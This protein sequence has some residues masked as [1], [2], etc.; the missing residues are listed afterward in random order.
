MRTLIRS[1]RVVLPLAALALTGSG[2]AAYGAVRDDGV[3]YRTARAGTGSVEQELSLAGVISP[4]GSSDLAFGVDGTVRKV[5]VRQGDE[6]E[7]GDVIAVLDRAG[8]RAAVDRAASDL[9]SAKAQLVDDRTAQTSAVATSST[10]PSS[11]NSSDEAASTSRDG[12]RPRSDN[13]DSS[14]SSASAGKQ[15]PDSTALIK[16]LEKQQEPV[17]TAQ[18]AASTALASAETALAEQQ[19]AC[20]DPVTTTKSTQAATDD[21][22]DGSTDDGGESTPT[23]VLSEACTSAL[24][25]VQTAQRT[26]STAQ[27]TLQ[28]ALETL[29]GTLADAA[30]SVTSDEAAPSSAPAPSAADTSGS[31]EPAPSDATSSDTS[32]TRSGSSPSPGDAGG[33][34]TAATLAQDQAAIDRASA[35]L[36]A[37]RSDLAGAVVRAPADGTIGSLAVAA[38]D[39]VSAGDTVGVVAAPG[40]TTVS[41][42]L[43][44]AQAAEVAPETH[45]EVTPA[46]ATDALD[47]SVTRVAHTQSS[48]TDTSSDPTYTAQIVLADRGLTLADGMTATVTLVVGSATDVVVLPASAVRDGSVTVL[49]NGRTRRVPVSTGV[50]GATAVE[51]TDGVDAGTEVVLADLDADLPTGET[52]D[53]QGPGRM[54]GGGFDGGGPPG[55]V[56][57]QR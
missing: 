28:T 21:D 43:T 39:D 25:A 56:V 23:P 47:G 33:T 11:D 19:E 41:V 1:R 5:R 34:V 22:P 8:L 57:R 17:L 30:R 24:A 3:D 32:P 10:T 38:G 49:E 6:V 50:V 44:A 29:T 36:A 14:P 16:K 20:A 9:A 55:T 42:E 31:S 12:T 54:G 52:D 35:D 26:A 18:T 13:A 27:S 15:S 37:A 51:I 53:R 4:A 7:K 45:V 46:G 2:L 40:L 48:S